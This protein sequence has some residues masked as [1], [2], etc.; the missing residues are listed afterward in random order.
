MWQLYAHLTRKTNGTDTL[1]C[2]LTGTLA[3]DGSNREAEM[4]EPIHSTFSPLSLAR[5]NDL[6]TA[7][8]EFWVI[9]SL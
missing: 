4:G 5:A 7:P 1:Q 8:F 3:G 6:F 2:Y 9:R